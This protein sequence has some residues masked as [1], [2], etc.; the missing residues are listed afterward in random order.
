LLLRCA[1][2]HKIAL[3]REQNGKEIPAKIEF[4]AGDLVLK[5]CLARP[6]RGFYYVLHLSAFLFQCQLL[7]ARGVPLLDYTDGQ[8]VRSHC[9]S[10]SSCHSVWPYATVEGAGRCVLE[11]LG[12]TQF[13]MIPRN[14]QIGQDCKFANWGEFMGCTWTYLYRQE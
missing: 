11:L 8:K 7:H 10:T 1:V 3:I 4:T 5:S 2:V 14:P 12:L 13:E 9:S 6:T